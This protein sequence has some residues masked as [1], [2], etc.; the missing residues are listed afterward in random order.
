M[1]NALAAK[2]KRGM[3]G[4]QVRV[5]SGSKDR[6]DTRLEHDSC[7]DEGVSDFLHQWES[8]YQRT[9]SMRQRKTMPTLASLTLQPKITDAT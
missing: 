9:V 3:G 1:K 4:I 5:R 6:D 8:L 7:P 2:E